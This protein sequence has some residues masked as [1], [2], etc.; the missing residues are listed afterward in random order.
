MKASLT[1]LALTLRFLERISRSSDKTL[2]IDVCTASSLSTGVVGVGV[3]GR[4]ML[5]GFML[6]LGDESSQEVVSKDAMA[7][8]VVISGM[9]SVDD[10]TGLDVVMI[11]VYVDCSI[12]GFYVFEFCALF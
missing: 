8:L 10:D 5:F 11:W 4:L 1:L 9:K 6:G 2:L 7:S 3:V 12:V